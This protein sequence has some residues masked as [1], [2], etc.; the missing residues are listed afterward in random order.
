M[1]S[2]LFRL[3]PVGTVYGG[4]M[5]WPI[6]AAAKILGWYRDYI[7]AA[8]N[9]INGFFALLNV[10]SGPPFPEAWHAKNTCAIV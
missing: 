8:P 4:P 1:T 2:L 10:P 3:H 9:Q 5:I 6:E 7:T